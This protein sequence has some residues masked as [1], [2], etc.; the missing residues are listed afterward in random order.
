QVRDVLYV[1]DLVD[2]MLGAMSAIGR[3]RG[4]AF[5]I[6]GGPTFTVSPCQVLAQLGE[7]SGNLPEIDYGAWRQGDQRYYASDIRAFGAAV[8]WQPKV[9]PRE[10]IERL[11]QWL[12]HDRPMHA[13]MLG[14]F[15]IAAAPV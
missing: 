10:G 9:A 5:N 8:G 13:A 11:Y 15:S 6:G 12:R 14:G 3:V 4:R 2:A 1:D 7:L